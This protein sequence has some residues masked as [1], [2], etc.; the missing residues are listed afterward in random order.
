M[1]PYVG[2]IWRVSTLNTGRC[3]FSTIVGVV[4][5]FPAILR[6][7]NSGGCFDG[8]AISFCVSSATGQARFSF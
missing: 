7:F 3:L 6:V 4:L 8:L 2:G 1:Q 5:H